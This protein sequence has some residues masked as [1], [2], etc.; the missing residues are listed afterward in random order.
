MVRI[1]IGWGID[2]CEAFDGSM[3][4]RHYINPKY[5]DGERLDG[6]FEYDPLIAWLRYVDGEIDIDSAKSPVAFSLGQSSLKKPMQDATSFPARS[7]PNS[8]DE[9]V[10]LES[11][12]W[13]L[14]Q[15]Q[16]GKR[17]DVAKSTALDAIHLLPGSPAY[18]G[19][20][21][22][23]GMAICEVE[24]TIKSPTAIPANAI[25]VA[26]GAASILASNIKDKE[27]K[28]SF[29]SSITVEAVEDW[30]CI[31]KGDIEIFFQ[32]TSMP[33]MLDG[34]I[35]FVINEKSDP[36]L[37]IGLGD[38]SDA[39]SAIASIDKSVD[40]RPRVLFFTKDAYLL[41]AGGDRLDFISLPLRAMAVEFPQE[42]S[43]ALTDARMLDNAISCIDSGQLWFLSDP[44]EGP[45]DLKVV[46]HTRQSFIKAMKIKRRQ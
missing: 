16:L 45:V 15:T 23:R 14:L 35:A 31:S 5:G 38:I 26:F 37:T 10:I 13:R 36:F 42:L 33:G 40:A 21:E 9:Y 32:G 18:V 4:I 2:C 24:S 29:L 28:E 41:V 39:I 25:R 17:D 27:E 1:R 46:G 34:T 30:F 20:T 3:L 7:V 6:A 12:D 11:D 8:K 19:T 22:G 44:R 43:Q